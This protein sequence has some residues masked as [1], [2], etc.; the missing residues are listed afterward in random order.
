MMCGYLAGSAVIRECTPKNKSGAFQGLRII[1]RVLVPGI[2]G[3]AVGAAILKDAE[4][5]VNNDGTASFIPDER[6]FLAA[7]VV[8][9]LV[10]AYLAVLFFSY[11][12]EINHEKT[13]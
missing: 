1:C 2:I 9:A 10:A 8:I 3:H 6:I 12:K 7:P 4:F 11:R 13:R 5:V